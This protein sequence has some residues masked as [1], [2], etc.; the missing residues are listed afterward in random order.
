MWYVQEHMLSLFTPP[1]IMW[2]VQELMLSL[3][4]TTFNHVVHTG[5]HA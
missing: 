3:F 1:V 4:F 2:Y 5:T